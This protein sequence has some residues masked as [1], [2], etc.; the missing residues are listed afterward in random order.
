MQIL[1]GLFVQNFC[2]TVP[3]NFV[4]EH[5]GVSENSVY[6]KILLHKKRISLNNVEKL[7]SHS[8]DK[9]C[10][11]TLRCFARILVSKI[12]KERKGEASRLRRSFLSHTTE[13]KRFVKKTFC[14]LEE[15]WFRKNFMDKM[16]HITIFSRNFHV[17]QCRKKF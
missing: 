17:S 2:L 13:T 10:G 1:S 9:I 6:R 11:R 4:G 7:L 14:F 8:I 15:F 16:G 12:F 3:K 5:F